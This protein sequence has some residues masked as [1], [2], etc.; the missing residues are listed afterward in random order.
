MKTNTNQSTE[1]H[2]TCT[3]CGTVH[4]SGLDETVTACP[5]CPEIQY[6]AI[7]TDGI[8]PVVWGIGE[9]ERE[10]LDDAGHWLDSE[11]DEG[12]ELLVVAI[13]AERAERVRSGDVRADDLVRKAAR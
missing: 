7:G 1:H 10:A 2:T 13:D 8:N 5:D 12:Q 11:G 9:D 3:T 6:A 4:D